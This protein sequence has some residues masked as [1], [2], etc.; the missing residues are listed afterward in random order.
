MTDHR[1][2]FGEYLLV[3][4]SKSEKRK[5]ARASEGLSQNKGTEVLIVIVI[6]IVVPYMTLILLITTDLIKHTNTPSGNL[7][8]A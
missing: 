8:L 1:P 5:A 7:Q 3:G 6:V 2:E 4:K